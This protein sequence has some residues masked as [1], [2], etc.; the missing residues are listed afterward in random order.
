[1]IVVLLPLCL[2]AQS[3]FSPSELGN[4]A[5]WEARPSWLSAVAGRYGVEKGDGGLRFWAEGK[6]KG[7]KFAAP[8]AP[9]ID[10]NV[11][12][13]LVVRYRCR[14]YDPDVDYLIWLSDASHRGGLYLVTSSHIKAD[15]AWH[16]IAADLMALGCS[17]IDTIATQVKCAGESGDVTFAPIQFAEAPP[18]SADLWLPAQP[19]TGLRAD[20]GPGQPKDWQAEP[21]WLANPS[22]DVS[23]AKTQSGVTFVVRGPGRGMKWSRLLDAPVEG[24]YVKLRYRARGLATWHDYVVYMAS[25]GGGRA[26]DEQYVL[27]LDQLLADGQWHTA[28]AFCQVRSVKTV[29]VQVQCAGEEAELEIACL[30]IWGGRPEQTLAEECPATPGWPDAETIRPAGFHPLPPPTGLTVKQAQ[31]VARLGGWWAGNKIT[32]AGIPFLVGDSAAGSSRAGLE[33]ITYD[34]PGRWR[35]LYMLLGASLPSQERP[36]Y[37]PARPQ[38][39]SYPHRFICELRYADGFTEQQMPTSLATREA[40]VRQGV[41]AYALSVD[42]SRALQ[43]LVIRDGHNRGAFV[44]YAVTASTKPGPADEVTAPRPA[45]KLKPQTRRSNVC[46]ITYADNKL[47]ADSGAIHLNLDL[48]RGVDLRS[49]TSDY[50][51]GVSTLVWQGSIFAVRVSDVEVRSAEVQ[52][53]GVHLSDDGRRAVIALNFSSRLPLAGTLTIAA[54]RRD[55][56]SLGL[57]L[58]PRQQMEAEPEVRFPLLEG[59][60]TGSVQDTWVFFPRCGAVISNRPMAFSAPHSGA[61]PLQVMGIFARTGGGLYVRTEYT[62]LAAC[63]YEVSKDR[64]GT[65]MAVRYPWWRGEKLTAVIGTNSDDWHGQLTA[66]D[67]WRRSWFQPVAPRKDWFRRIFNFRQQFLTFTVPR[68][69][70]LFDP[71]TKTFHF[72]EVI[73]HDEE[74]FGGIDYLHLFDWGWSPSHGRCGDYAPW[75]Y[76]GPPDNFRREIER[77]QASGLPVG[78][79]I[80]GRLVS[81]ESSMFK[82]AEPWQIIDAH[83]KPIQ[84]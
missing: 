4:P 7:M 32:V 37:N 52:V 43:Q 58:S 46:R 69:S 77:L 75:D 36:G 54:L 40:V 27:Y 47:Q 39:V 66:Y 22:S 20:I 9:G 26:P 63:L 35:Q 38:T 42:S 82:A 48:A 56:L 49:L 41:G 5:T 3:A 16:T 61:F 10:V 17:Q 30:Q 78:L 57:E 13:W 70:G 71:K 1:M 80:E 62:E 65:H 73:K 50:L 68:A 74:A 31:A 2:V 25:Q 21:S 28:V 23:V 11:H 34:A 24:G 14:N 33:E 51:P 53:K 83:G 18:Q 45:P 84:P 72:D 81:P 6:G 8:L 60:R 29:A 15:G 44:L 67:A 79:Y 59:C 76:L 64:H 55:E 12:P 19:A